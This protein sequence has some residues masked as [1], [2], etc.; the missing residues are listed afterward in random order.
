MDEMQEVIYSNIVTKKWSDILN[1]HSQ[2]YSS[3]KIESPD[4]QS[5]V[6]NLNKNL[7]SKVTALA[8]LVGEKRKDE[9]V[10]S[11]R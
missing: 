11:K 9:M 6:I 3:A 7:S 5:E 1:L 8:R 10:S 4:S 2:F